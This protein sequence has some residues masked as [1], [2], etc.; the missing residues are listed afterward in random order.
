MTIRLRMLL[1]A[2]ALLCI[3]SPPVGAQQAVFSFDPSATRIRFT[4]G[5]TLHA[6]HGTMQLKRGE[7][8]FD[9]ATGNAS[10]EVV[11]DATS[12]ETGNKS[13]DHKMH[14]E[15]LESAMYP[16]I[17]FTA[18]HVSGAI[19]ETGETQLQ[20]TGIFELAGTKHPM[21]LPVSFHRAAPG[22]SAHA[23]TT[24][25]VP[26]VEWG[27]RN[28]STLFLRVSDHVDMEIEATGRL[29]GE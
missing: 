22:D 5:A 17:I 15:V 18:E 12:A 4:L 14:K 3:L 10:G 21:T 26:Y 28:P 7:I 13:R 9:P 6:V 25:A 29:S 11:V 20:L 8:H 24:F 19:Q 1:G 23:R 16:E 27:L 2:A